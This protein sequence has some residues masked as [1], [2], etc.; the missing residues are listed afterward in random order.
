MWAFLVFICKNFNLPDYIIVP[1]MRK[2]LIYIYH[3]ND[4]FPLHICRPL[5]NETVFRFLDFFRFYLLYII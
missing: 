3:I 5:S 1:L 4:A 2:H